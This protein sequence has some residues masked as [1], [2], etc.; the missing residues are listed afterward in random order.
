[1]RRAET[2]FTLI[3]VLVALVMASVLLVIIMDGAVAARTRQ[4]AATEHQDAVRLAQSIL[5]Q[6][7]AGGAMAAIDRGSE[8]GLDWNIARSVIAADRRGIYALI[9][10]RV[11]ITKEGRRLE[12]FTARRLQR[13]A[14]S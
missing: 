13:V 8:G 4:R 1:M 3:E 9:E 6:A 7:R 5:E 14:A 2:G 10:I 11:D 12:S